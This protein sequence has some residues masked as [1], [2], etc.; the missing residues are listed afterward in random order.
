MIG[1]PD[2]VFTRYLKENTIF[3]NKHTTHS[4]K[5]KGGGDMLIE[6]IEIWSLYVYLN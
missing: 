1:T 3:N 4:L 6:M 2:A 5:N